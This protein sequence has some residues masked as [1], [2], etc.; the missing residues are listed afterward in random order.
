MTIIRRIRSIGRKMA[1]YILDTDHISLFLG[2]HQPTYDRVRREFANCSVTIISVHEV[3][4]GWA[5]K[6]G[7]IANEDARIIAY[8]K[9]YSASYFFQSLTIVKYE[10]SASHLYQQLIQANPTLDKRRLENDVRIAAIAL[11]H[12]ATVVTRNRK[13]FGLVPGLTIEDWSV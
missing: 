10:L 7:R 2:N 5:G 13:D 8:D 1:R 12:N 4:N 11:T 6:L 9:L 3:F